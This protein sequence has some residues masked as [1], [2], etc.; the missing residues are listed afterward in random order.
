[1]DSRTGV[2]AGEAITPTDDHGERSAA[3]ALLDTVPGTHLKTLGADKSCDTRHFN[4]DR[5]HRGSD[6]ATGQ[7]HDPLGRQRRQRGHHPPLWLRGQLGRAVTGRP[8]RWGNSPPEPLRRKHVQHRSCAAIHDVLQ[9]AK[10][11]V[12]AALHFRAEHHDHTGGFRPLEA[13]DGARHHSNGLAD[14]REL[15]FPNHGRVEA[16]RQFLCG[17][18]DCDLSRVESLLADGPLEQRDAG[19]DPFPA[20]VKW[21]NTG[22]KPSTPSE[23]TG[24]SKTDATVLAIGRVLRQFLISSYCGHWRFAIHAS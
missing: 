24:S 23:W 7:P 8:A 6:V 21:W 19:S 2:M 9:F 3:P 1:M 18:E 15:V 10:L 22:S 17:G 12:P 4:P 13:V 16:L 20:G 5:R 11:L 14:G